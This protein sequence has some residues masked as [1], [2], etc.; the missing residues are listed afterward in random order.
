METTRITKKL[1]RKIL[2]QCHFERQAGAIVHDLSGQSYEFG[3][4]ERLEKN[5]IRWGWVHD[6]GRI[7]ITSEGLNQV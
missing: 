1:A 7:V 6:I 2:S 4:D 5:L 3:F